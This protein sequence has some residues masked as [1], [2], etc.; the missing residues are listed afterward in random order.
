MFEWTVKCSCGFFNRMDLSILQKDGYRCAK[1]NCHRLLNISSGKWVP[2]QPS[3]LDKCW[4]FHLSQFMEPS[5]SH[6]DIWEVYTSQFTSPRTFHNEVLGLAYDIG[7]L[8]LTEEIM[9][10]ACNPDQGEVNIHCPDVWEGETSYPAASRPPFGGVDYGTGESEKSSYTVYAQGDADNDGVFNIRYIRRFTGPEADLAGQAKIIDALARNGKVRWCGA[11]WGFGAVT[12][13][14]L[15][16]EFGWSPTPDAGTVTMLEFMIGPPNMLGRA[17]W[18]KEASRYLLNRT[19]VMAEFIDAIRTG[20]VR[21]PNFEL[22]KNK[23][24]LKDFLNV[25]VEYNDRTGKFSFGR[26]GADD[27]FHACM[28]A[29]AA[30]LQSSG[31]LVPTLQSPYVQPAYADDP[32]VHAAHGDAMRF[33]DEFGFDQDGYAN[34]D[35]TFWR[36]PMG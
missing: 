35:P 22:M 4:G 2:D 10:A 15:I 30:Y 27:V 5:M 23:L 8:A 3:K 9:A 33:G 20:K 31:R 24:F 17:R 6:A 11:D 12:N 36:G 18:K 34:A 14:R 25:F 26:N 29:W 21:F 28:Y 19:I 1:K 13:R 32:I 16:S 7:E